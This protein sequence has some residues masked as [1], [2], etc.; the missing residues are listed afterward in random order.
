M[1]VSTECPSVLLPYSQFRFDVAAC[2]FRRN[3]DGAVNDSRFHNDI[4]FKPHHVAKTEMAEKQP[5]SGRIVM[6]SL[7]NQE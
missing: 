6:K 1:T 7:D 3:G 5:K 4:R 2:R